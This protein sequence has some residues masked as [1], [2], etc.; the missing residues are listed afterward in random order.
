MNESRVL[1][2]LRQ[3]CQCRCCDHGE[4]SDCACDCHAIGKCAWEPSA[5]LASPLIRAEEKADGLPVSH[6]V[7]AENQPPERN[8]QR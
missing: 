5:P 2:S 8:G 1:N 3:G 7:S 6:S 4:G